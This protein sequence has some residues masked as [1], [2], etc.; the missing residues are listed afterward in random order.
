MRVVYDEFKEVI[1]LQY[2][3]TEANPWYF[4]GYIGRTGKYLNII[5]W[6]RRTY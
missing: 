4:S 6:H 5:L 1:G 3:G 2:E